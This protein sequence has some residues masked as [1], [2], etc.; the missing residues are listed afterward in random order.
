V[1]DGKLYGCTNGQDGICACHF[2]SLSS[3]VGTR[4]P[5]RLLLPICLSETSS[6]S[7]IKL[8]PFHSHLSRR[9]PH[10]C[11]K[12]LPTYPCTF[13]LLSIGSAASKEKGLHMPLHLHDLVKQKPYGIQKRSFAVIKNSDYHPSMLDCSHREQYDGVNEEPVVIRSEAS[14]IPVASN[15]EQE[16][17][18][19]RR[20]SS[21]RRELIQPE[22][23]LDNTSVGV[24]RPISSGSLR[25]REQFTFTECRIRP[26]KIRTK[27]NEPSDDDTKQ[28]SL[29]STREVATPI[30]ET[31]K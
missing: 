26:Q 9:V 11:V 2:F 12:N 25:E 1:V 17:P 5:T 10:F 14:D 16:S 23:F 30:H 28:E 29:A 3:R 15:R 22:E 31:E 7:F 21:W 13:F 19:A 24:Q 6:E 20:V 8:I 4:T 27:V 18:N